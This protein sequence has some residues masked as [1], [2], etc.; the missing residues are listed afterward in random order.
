M[1]NHRESGK[2]LVKAIASSSPLFI[3]YDLLKCVQFVCLCSSSV[4]YKDTMELCCKLREM[5]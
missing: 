3:A 1:L 5:V 4:G 2:S